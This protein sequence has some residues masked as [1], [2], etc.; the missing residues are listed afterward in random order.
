M[1]PRERHGMTGTAIYARWK[2]IKRRTTKPDD[3]GYKNYGGRGIKMCP[4]WFNSFSVFYRDIGNPPTPRHTIERIDNNKGYEPGNVK[5]A[6]YGEQARNKRLLR[7]NKNGL[8]G[9]YKTRNTFY[10]ILVIDKKRKYLGSFAT[11]EQAH[12]AYKEALKVN[13]IYT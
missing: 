8:T 4:E 1:K 13:G 3:S 11:A 6:T 5:W 12:H 10:S 9:V 2:Q 7:K